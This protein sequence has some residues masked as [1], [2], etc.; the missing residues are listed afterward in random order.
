MLH[1]EIFFVPVFLTIAAKFRK[2]SRTEIGSMSG[3]SFWL[4]ANMSKV[5]VCQIIVKQ[6]SDKLWISNQKTVASATV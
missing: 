4:V 5:M 1:D 2:K 3:I 6:L